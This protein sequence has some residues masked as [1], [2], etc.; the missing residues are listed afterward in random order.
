MEVLAEH[1]KEKKGY[2]LFDKEKLKKG[3]HPGSKSW[4]LL[5]LYYLIQAREHTKTHKYTYSLLVVSLLV[6][7]YRRNPDLFKRAI[8]YVYQLI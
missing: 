6:F 8:K 2:G 5:A 4:T 1:R 3:I 7:F